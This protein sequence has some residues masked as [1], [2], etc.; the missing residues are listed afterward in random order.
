GMAIRMT[1]GMLE[2]GR[3]RHADALAALE[4]GD[5]LA[6]RLAEPSLLVVPVHA[7]LVQTLVRLGE[8][9]LAE[10]ALAQLNG[11][12]QDS[13]LM[14]ISLAVLRLGQHNPQ[15]A[16]AALAP[17]LHGSAPGPWSGQPALSL[18]EVTF[19]GGT[20]LLEAIVQDALGDSDAAA[21]ALE[22]AL[23]LAEPDGALE[24]F[25][26]YPEPDLLERHARQGTA[27]AALIADILSLLAGRQL[28]PQPAGPEPLLEAL[29]DSE[30]RVLRYLPTNLTRPHIAP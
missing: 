10:R 5:R 24:I 27:H 16:I 22:R 30:I 4:A 9:E 14:R 13:A 26:R 23:D 29:S 11:Q 3:G 20:F 12:D 17:V 2:I 15:E 8:T 6:G 1:R 19:W 18:P 21:S 28:A 25:L 7:M